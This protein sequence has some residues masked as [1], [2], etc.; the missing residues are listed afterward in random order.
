MINRDNVEMSPR[1]PTAQTLTIICDATGKPLPQ[2][3]WLVFF[4]TLIFHYRS[5]FHSN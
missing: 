5:I 4:A 3:F 1:L 2:I